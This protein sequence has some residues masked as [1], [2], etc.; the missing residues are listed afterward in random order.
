MLFEVRTLFCIFNIYK[1]K[2]KISSLQV[3]Q[4]PLHIIEIIEVFFSS[5]N[6]A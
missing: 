2:K 1:K 5:I 4:L 3:F 6:T